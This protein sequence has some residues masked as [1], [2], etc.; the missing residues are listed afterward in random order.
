MKEV[1]LLIAFYVK[2]SYAGIVG[3]IQIHRLATTLEHLTWMKTISLGT[4][5]T[6]LLEACIAHAFH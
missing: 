5:D 6:L 2:F 4:A 1:I 3:A